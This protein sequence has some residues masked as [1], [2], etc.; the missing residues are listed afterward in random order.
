MRSIRGTRGMAVA[1]HALAAQSALAVLR[2]GGN[3]LEA[4]VACAATI[5]VV[6]PH[7]NSIGGD[8]FWLVSVPGEAPRA[9]DA[10]GA[11]ASRA[12]IEW[13][14]ERGVSGSLPARG[15]LA[16][17]TVAGTVAGWELALGEA[18][19]MGGKLPLSRLLADAVDYAIRGIP[20]SGSLARTIAAKQ[21]ELGALPG[22]APVF[23][24][25][26]AAPRE[27]ERLVQPRLAAALH[28]LS[29]AGLDDFYRGDLAR[30]IAADLEKLGSPVSLNDLIMHRARWRTPLALAHSKGTVFNLPPP[31]QGLVSLLILGQLDRIGLDGLAHDHPAFVHLAVE[32][33]KQAFAIRNRY[34]TD[35]T[36]MAV[37]AQGFL[38]ADAL[39]AMAASIVPD[40]AAPWPPLPG[41]G[42]TVWMGV[43]DDAGRAV[44]CIQ[45]IYHEF[46]SGIVL[47]ESGINWQNRGVSFALD[48]AALNALVPGRKP[49]HTLNPA[50]AQLHDGRT[51]VFGTMGGDG[52]PQTQSAIFSRY[53]NFE[54]DP[55]AAVD[56]PRWRL[57]RAW[58]Q[59]SDTLKLESRF[60]EAT[61]SRLREFGHEIEMLGAYDESMGHAGMLVRHAN[62]TLEGGSDPRSD[63]CVAAF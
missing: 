19:K 45:S 36:Y 60:P 61:V 54:L 25:G 28:H 2:E 8:A 43:I 22:Y 12:S 1:P 10:C 24:P 17:L 15:P 50:L 5:A 33:T 3:A 44:S 38:E 9:I 41:P 58:G 13:Y 26:G 34:V 56:A 20:V 29:A 48:P 53:V 30:S 32:A 11:A 49:F 23:L 57:G 46:G 51:V 14:A 42:D 62:G 27:G 59:D 4:M 31:T 37:E 6:Y 18:R 55:Q 35:P 40:R 16:A 39:R 21:T 52:Q 7:M 47:G 63:G